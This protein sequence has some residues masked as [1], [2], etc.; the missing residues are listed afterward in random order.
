MVAASQCPSLDRRRVSILPIWAPLRAVATLNFKMLVSTNVSSNCHVVGA[1]G[2]NGGDIDGNGI[3]NGN[4]DSAASAQAD[5]SD[6]AGS[7]TPPGHAAATEGT[8]PRSGPCAPVP[9]AAAG[10]AARRA[11]HPSPRL[12][13]P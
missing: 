10:D 3:G 13:G 2:D 9:G 1:A 12:G 11:S 4:G 8:C 6:I 5:D 7:G